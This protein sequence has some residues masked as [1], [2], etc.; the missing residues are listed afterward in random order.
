[1]VKSAFGPQEEIRIEPNMMVEKN[2][3]FIFLIFDDLTN[4]YLMETTKSHNELSNMYGRLGK[5]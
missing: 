1:V 3:F 2:I 4:F 5:N